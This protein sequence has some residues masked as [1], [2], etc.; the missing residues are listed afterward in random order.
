MASR[1]FRL[2][3]STKL[4]IAMVGRRT[5]PAI[6]KSFKR[7]EHQLKIIFT[8]LIQAVIDVELLRAA[9]FHDLDSIDSI[10]GGEG[11]AAR[12]LFHILF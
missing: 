9:I 6:D 12:M 1:P 4:L 2:S 10:D 8:M 5:I 7:R 11:R 3:V